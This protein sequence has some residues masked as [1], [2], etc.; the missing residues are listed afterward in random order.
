MQDSDNLKLQ[1][2]RVKS[3]DEVKASSKN[4][5]AK[6]IIESGAKMLRS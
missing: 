5:L 2:Y 1:R 3:F 6:L 4:T